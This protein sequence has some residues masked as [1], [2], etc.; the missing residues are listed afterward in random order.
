M[1]INLITI[2]KFEFEICFGDCIELLFSSLAVAQALI[3]AK[4]YKTIIFNAR[5]YLTD[6]FK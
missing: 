4:K 5:N 3:L 2:Y 6:L 1:K